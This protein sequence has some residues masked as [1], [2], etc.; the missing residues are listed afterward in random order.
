VSERSDPR[1]DPAIDRIAQADSANDQATLARALRP[2]AALD[3]LLEEER[4]ALG[5]AEPAALMSLA[6]RK[7]HLLGTLEAMQ[8]ALG[9]ALARTPIEDARRREILAALRACR[10]SNAENGVTAGTTV[11]HLRSTL[12]LLRTTLALDDLVLYD[13][14]GELLARHE[15]RVLG[16][17]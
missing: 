1:S 4:A 13:E 14:H 15:R 17:A 8:P 6:S 3:A 9:E 11:H 7:F 10:E 16:R 12:S 5:K 2:I